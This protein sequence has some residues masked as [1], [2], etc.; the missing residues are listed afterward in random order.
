LKQLICES[1]LH[2]IATGSYLI[3][4]ETSFDQIEAT[5]IVG[6][7]SI[8]ICSKIT[9]C[10]QQHIALGDFELSNTMNFE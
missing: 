4:K 9:Y 2:I 8:L 5:Y 3:L 1:L 6:T 7:K 10:L